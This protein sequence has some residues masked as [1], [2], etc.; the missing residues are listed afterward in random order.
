[1]P[2]IHATTCCSLLLLS[3]V[4]GLACACGQPPSSLPLLTHLVKFVQLCPAM[5]LSIQLPPP[6]PLLRV[7]HDTPDERYVR[8]TYC[9]G[10]RA[11][12][13][14]LGSPTEEKLVLQA[15][16]SSTRMSSSLQVSTVSKILVPGPS[17]FR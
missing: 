17:R 14:K 4:P 11:A 13:S 3:L 16:S 5:P 12:G 6:R 10:R 7:A 1:M 2:I 9:G 8:R 15:Q